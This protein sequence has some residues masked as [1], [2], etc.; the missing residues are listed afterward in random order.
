MADGCP[1]CD[2]PSMAGGAGETGY[3]RKGDTSIAYRVI[4]DGPVDLVFGAGF[5]CHLDLLKGDPHCEAWVRGLARLGRLIV[6]DKPGTGLSDPLTETPTLG[7]RVDDHL[8]VM[9]AVGSQRAVLVAF[10]E[11]CAPA[12]LLSATHPDRIEGLVTVS[13][14]VRPTCDESYL[15]QLDD[16]LERF[17]WRHL[18]HSRDNWGD[19]SLVQSMSP[20]ARSSPVYRRLS[21]TIE[22]ACASPGMARRI[23]DGLRAYDGLAAAEAV[24]VPT[25]VLNRSDEWVP[26]DVAVD[27][28]ERVPGAKLAL[29]PGEE[30]LCYF[31]GEDLLAEIE[32]FVGGT[33]S[34][35]APRRE[36][37]ALLTLLF[38]DIVGSTS[39]AADMGDDRW[40]A[41]LA[42]HH[43]V[44]ADV[45][46]RL[47]GR[48]AKSTGDGTLAA[49]DRPAL[50]L[51][52]AAL[53]H[54]AAEDLGIGL[55]AGLHTGECEL[56][57]DDVSGIAVHL[58]ARVAAVAGERET[59][60]TATV[61]DLVLGSDVTWEDRG[62]HALKGVPGS[63]S[64]VAVSGRSAA[65]QAPVPTGDG[66]RPRD[67]AMM[68][69]AGRAPVVT[70]AVLRT[71]GR[72]RVRPD[73]SRSS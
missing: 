44:A 43:E 71:V 6:F 39:A 49:F 2:D 12:L 25:L 15:P 65:P 10:S 61:R 1:F 28:A 4:G 69:A 32:R 22:R 47:G 48:F 23:I 14:V 16:Y 73:V 54:E 50:A 38:T 19:G 42:R 64:L 21:S 46:G 45:V 11:A 36:E 37:R 62:A 56:V 70:R 57:G 17:I 3:A 59:L 30:H 41:L 34:R 5:A 66:M 68:A 20:F 52:A 72:W 33:V 67:R 8:A 53:L 9:D 13:G 51:R 55:R 31:G 26:K 58:A 35:A 7:D 60:A 40:C 29:L 24:R 18:W 27:L 63:W